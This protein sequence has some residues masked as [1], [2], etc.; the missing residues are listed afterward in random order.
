VVDNNLRLEK[1]ET[2]TIGPCPGQGT[3]TK[4][5]RG[6]AYVATIVC[7]PC[8]KDTPTGPVSLTLCRIL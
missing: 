1:T 6:G 5:R 3:H 4:V 2:A 7:C 8:C